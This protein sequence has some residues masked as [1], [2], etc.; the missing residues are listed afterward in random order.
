MIALSDIIREE[1]NEAI[2]TLRRQG[3][4]TAMLTGD[5]KLTAAYVAKELDLDTYFADVL[6][7]QK[8]EKIQELQSQGYKVAMV[9]DGVNDAPAL[10]Q[11]E[12][13]IA[14]G[15]GTDVAVESA[16]IVL[17]KNN[18]LDIVNLFELS[19]ATSS[20][21]KQNLAWATG[22]NT[23]AIPVAAGVLFPL[24]VTLRP[25]IAAIIMALSSI[26]V[27]TNAFLLKKLNL[28]R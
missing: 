5:N 10:I 15:A 13:G 20:K 24:G 27:V 23:L 2:N 19:H 4:K 21:M 9:G 26:I 16:Q 17:V 28:K 12:M 8:A 7:E 11:A 18:P 6:P 3:V 22:Y 14:I 25:E 1:S